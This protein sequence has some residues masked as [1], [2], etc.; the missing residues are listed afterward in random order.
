VF[1]DI[2]IDGISICLWGSEERKLAELKKK[3]QYLR[4]QPPPSG[5]LTSSSSG[6]MITLATQLW[7]KNYRR[8]GS[9][10]QSEVPSDRY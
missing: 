2:Y 9:Y 7:P 6:N 5:N 3:Q 4:V 1:K 10:Y 8:S